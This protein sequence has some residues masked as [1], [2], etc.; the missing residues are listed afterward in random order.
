MRPI[1]RRS[2]RPAAPSSTCGMRTLPDSSGIARSVP[3]LPARSASRRSTG[4]PGA[5]LS[6]VAFS[7][8]HRWTN[9][10]AH[11]RARKPGHGIG[12]AGG[13]QHFLEERRDLVGSRHPADDIVAGMDDDR[14]ARLGRE[15]RVEAG[16]AVRLGGREPEPL[17]NVIE[18]AFAD[19]ADRVDEG[20]ERGQQEVS[21]G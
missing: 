11:A 13:A 6:T 4:G 1:R 9:A 2:R 12:P 3:S 21:R 17:A 10:R 8:L 18:S 14:R 15:Q 7:A 16:D 19:P 20:V 5:R